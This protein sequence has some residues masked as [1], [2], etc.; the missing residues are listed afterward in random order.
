MRYVLVT[1]LLILIIGA[2]GAVKACQFAA[3]AEQGAEAERAG[4]P[5]EAVGT[6][7]VVSQ[8][9]PIT[10]EAVGSLTS[11]RGLSVRNEVPG[12]V[13]RLRFRSGERVKR[14]EILVELDA[15]VERAAL[16]SAL[17]AIELATINVKRFAPLAESGAASQA[18]LD[19]AENQLEAATARAAE[20]RAEIAR[21]VVRAPF[22]G[23]LGIREVDLGQYLPAGTAITVLET[24]NAALVDFAIPQGKIDDVE[25][26]MP[27]KIEVG[28][29]REPL[30]GVVAAVAPA[31]DAETRTARLRA[32][33]VDERG[34]LR[35]GMFVHVEVVLGERR[36]PVVPATAIVHASYGDSVF[37]V[38]DKGPREPGA[39]ET[40]DRRPIRAA[41]QRFVRLGPRRGD[42][43]AILEGVSPGDEVVSA[44]AF[45]LRDGAPVVVTTAA[46]P[47]P[48]LAPRPA[49]R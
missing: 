42:F 38:E 13:S 14:G 10:L 2:L 15:S 46:V 20:L 30:A 3:L 28:A 5:P 21:K 36:L 1:A 35:R 24:A 32:S 37:V 6:F 12:V 31:L 41:R 11:A 45:K 39:R 26:G 29:G 43:V 40:P 47:E 18:E 34:E 19:E 25:A 48:E 8:T 27:V 22:S 7:R 33:V 44:G 9:W 49:N 17:A 16:A 23:R 4:P